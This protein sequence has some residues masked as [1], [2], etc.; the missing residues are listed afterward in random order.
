MADTVSV[1]TAIPSPTF[2]TE[3]I[4]VPDLADVLAGAQT[5]IG[6]ALGD[7][8]S[9]SLSTPQGQIAMS[10][11]AVIGSKDSAL[12]A[13]ANNINP[14]YSSGRYQDAIGQIYF[15]SRKAATGTTVTATCTGAVGTVIPAGSYAQDSAG[16]IYASSSEETI[17]SDGSASVTFVNLTTGAI[18]C[19]AGALNAVYQSV[20]GWSGITN[21]AS[22]V[23]GSD[24]ETRNAFEQRRR[25]MV[26]NGGVNS[27]LSLTGALVGLDGVTDVYVRSNNTTAAISVG[28]TSVTIPVG[29][30]YIAVY[31]GSDDDIGD[32]I[33]TKLQ[34]CCATMGSESYIYADTEN[35]SSN[36]P[37][38]TYQ[39][40]VPTTVDIYMKVEIE[41]NE[42][43]STSI[44][45]DIQSAVISAFSGDDGGTKASIGDS[46]YASRYYGPIQDVDT[47]NLNIVSVLVSTDGTTFSNSVELGIDQLPVISTSNIT[48]TKDS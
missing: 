9:T 12:L 21:Y 46:I 38:Y 5:D 37:T 3:G 8:A 16:Y 26:A 44:A 48:V 30:C 33:H 4:T 29:T 23:L 15:I 25:N 19:A 31:G 41:G 40:T 28:S 45:S 18:E 13:F 27:V 6:T 34:P 35:Y 24:E 1:Y 39:W 10:R 22:G 43:L 14:D 17:G 32:A 7:D 2:S 36:Y 11:A 47:K 20:S 42:F